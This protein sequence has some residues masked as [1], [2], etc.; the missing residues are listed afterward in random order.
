MEG[1]FDIMDTLKNIFIGII[2][3]SVFAMIIVL[4]SGCSAEKY[5]VEYDNKDF[6][7]FARNSYRP[8]KKV[9][10]YYKK[11]LIGTDTDYYFYLDGERIEAVYEEK[12]FRIEFVMPEHDVSLSRDSV[13]SMYCP[14]AEDYEGGDEMPENG[15]IQTEETEQSIHN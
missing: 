4:F 8:G 12:G 2:A 14:V 5:N 6:Y 7:L 11:E 3:V 9:T 1:F 15:D 10:V 13:N